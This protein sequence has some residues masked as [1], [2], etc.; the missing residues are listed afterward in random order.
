MRKFSLFIFD[1]DNTIYDWYA[2]FLPAFY[3]MVDVASTQLGCSVEDLLSD[4]KRIHIKH[5]DVEHPYSLVETTVVKNLLEEK[6]RAAAW[7]LID[8]AFHA[9]NKVRKEHLKLFPDTLPT[10]TALRSQGVQLVAY[11]DS[12]YFAAR[13]RIERLGLSDVF[14]KVYCRER[15]QS[16][17]P[18]QEFAAKKPSALDNITEIPSH[19]SKPNPVV[20]A[21]I[22]SRQNCD[23]HEAAYVGDSLSK[24]I[25]M[26]KHAGCFAVWAKYGAHT[27]AAMY[28]RLIRISHWTEDDIQRERNYATAAKNIEP[29]FVCE[30][31]IAELLGLFH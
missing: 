19:Q 20:L 10:L 25:L 17:L 18:V 12:T 7:E 2:A 9:F 11:T 23:M 22:V 27:D 14:S 26:A 24:D 21:D 29:D 31:S 3:E 5:H 30:R 8:P 28:E 1:L 15:G 13:G 6:G 16:I 4:L